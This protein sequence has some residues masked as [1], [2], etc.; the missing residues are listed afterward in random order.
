[1]K[2]RD[3]KLQLHRE[4]VRQLE[5]RQEELVQARGGAV[6]ALQQVDRWSSCIT[7]DCC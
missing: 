3:K 1:M 7:P 6:E 5:I 4:T 2:K